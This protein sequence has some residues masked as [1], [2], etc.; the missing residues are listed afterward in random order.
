[1]SD[2]VIWV[3]MQLDSQ[4]QQHSLGRVSGVLG[5]KVWNDVQVYNYAS[6]TVSVLIHLSPA[7]I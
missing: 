1:M 2:H 7:N 5:E 6:T 4:D 3:V